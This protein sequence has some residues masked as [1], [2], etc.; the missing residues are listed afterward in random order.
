MISLTCGS[1]VICC[2]SPP[3]MLKSRSLDRGFVVD[4]D[5]GF[6]DD[7]VLCRKVARR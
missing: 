1:D 7:D 6:T 4:V 3:L 5:D 2:M